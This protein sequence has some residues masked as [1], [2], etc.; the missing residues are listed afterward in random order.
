[1]R[2]EDKR[3]RFLVNPELMLSNGEVKT[4]RIGAKPGPKN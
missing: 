2:V 3:Q 4:N 1:V